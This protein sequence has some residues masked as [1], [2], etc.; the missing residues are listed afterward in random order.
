ME[1]LM[2]GVAAASLGMAAVM[3]AIGLAQGV[4]AL[5][6]TQA[7]AALV[8]LGMARLQRQE[9]AAVAA[10]V[11]GDLVAINHQARVVGLDF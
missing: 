9:L 5:V 3:V 6:V 11:R 4:T 1:E 7:T 10:V 8:K 2:K